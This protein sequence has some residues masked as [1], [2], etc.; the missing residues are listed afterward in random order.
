MKL[1][2]SIEG[3]LGLGAV[4][5]VAALVILL[6]MNQPAVAQSCI[7]EQA[8][9]SLVCTAN[10][11]RVAYADNIR[12]T[13]GTSLSQCVRGS[14]F[15]FI[16][17]FH[18]QTTA[19]SRYD[20]GLYFATDGDPNGNGARSGVCSANI[21]K[22]PYID[23]V[24]GVVTLGA[25][26]A[27]N[28]DGD[29]CFDINT[30]NGW[31]QTGGQIVTVRVDNVL[32][33]DSDNDGKLNLPNCT[34]WSQNTGVVCTTPQLAAPGSPSKC[35]CDIGFNVPIFVETGSIQV[36]KDASP[37]SRPE[38]GGDFV[39]TVGVHNTAAFTSL[40]LDRICDDK[41]G[42]IAKVASAPACPAGSLGPIKPG[43]TCSVPQTLAPGGNYSCSFT[44]SV[45]SDVATTVTNVVTMFGHDQNNVA[46]QGSDS[47]QVAITDV[48]PTAAVVK[49]LVGLACADVNYRV[50][51]DNTDASESL[52]L[53]ALSDS[54]FGS[55][56]SVHGDVLATNCGV[57]APTGPGTLPATI[58]VG[59]SYEC[60]FRAHFCGGSHTDTV[61]ATVN[62]DDNSSI[63][64]TSNSLTVNVS[65]N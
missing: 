5:S 44:G 33:Q 7:E 1:S 56:T 30:A 50:R 45:I 58:P 12:N 14:T 60:E 59:G 42:L 57:A 10:D 43:T 35:N 20:I 17:D 52:T 18:V 61:T 49:S 40:T 64:P 25:A 27:I 51:V 15:S 55:I 65:A 21:I 22:Q 9:R 46:L 23:P 63:T 6:L 26:S 36:T 19:T 28:L 32:C 54:G 3:K 11:V 16:A 47:A 48:A 8:G 13:A 62:D 41:Y 37:A 24:S 39:F 4:V 29:G 53:T 31:G 34:S 38:P 2:K